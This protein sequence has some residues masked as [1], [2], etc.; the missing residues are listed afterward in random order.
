MNDD[1]DAWRELAEQ[2]A[3]LIATELDRAE[4]AR[5]DDGN[6][7]LWAN[8][9]LAGLGIALRLAGS[10][11]AD[12]EIP[13]ARFVAVDERGFWGVVEDFCTGGVSGVSILGEGL[14]I[15]FAV[16]PEELLAPLP[17]VALIEDEEHGVIGAFDRH[18]PVDLTQEPLLP[19][20]RYDQIDCK[21]AKAAV[22][23]AA[24]PPYGLRTGPEPFW[25]WVGPNGER[26]LLAEV[27][28]LGPWSPAEGAFFAFSSREEA[29]RAQSCLR[30][31]LSL[32][33]SGTYTAAPETWQVERISSLRDWMKSTLVQSKFQISRFLIDPH[34]PR[35]EVGFGDSYLGPVLR[36]SAG[37]WNLEPDGRIVLDHIC[38]EWSERDT[39]HWDGSFGW[40]CNLPRTSYGMP[41]TGPIADK[42]TSSLRA[43]ER[44]AARISE[45]RYGPPDKLADSYLVIQANAVDLSI[46]FRFFADELA[47]LAKLLDEVRTGIVESHGDQ[48]AAWNSR[49]V[50]ENGV[51]G[52]ARRALTEDYDPSRAREVA[53]LANAVLLGNRIEVC[54][55]VTDVAYALRSHPARMELL[56][57]ALGLEGPPVRARIIAGGAYDLEPQAIR[58]GTDALGE[59]VWSALSSEAQWFVGTGLLQK[60]RL[61]TDLHVD[62]AGFTIQLGRAL[63]IE[64]SHLFQEVRTSLEGADLAGGDSPLDR[65]LSGGRDLTIGEAL[66]YLKE[67]ES[68]GSPAAQT[69]RTYI[70]NDLGAGALLVNP[71]V[72][73]LTK[74]NASVR[75][76]SAHTDVVTDEN[77][78]KAM[79]LVLGTGER[80]GLL[81]MLIDAVGSIDY[82]Q[83]EPADIGGRREVLRDA[84]SVKF[85]A[86][87]LA[88]RSPAPSDALGEAPSDEGFGSGLTE[89]V[90]G[91]AVTRRI[92]DLGIMKLLNGGLGLSASF[93]AEDGVVDI[94]AQ[95]WDRETVESLDKA[96]ARK[97][98]SWT[99]KRQCDIDTD[100]P[101]GG[102]VVR[103]T[104][105][106]GKSASVLLSPEQASQFAT[107]VAQ[108]NAGEWGP[109]P[110]RKDSR[111]VFE[112]RSVLIESMWAA[113][114]AEGP[115][116]RMDGI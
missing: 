64:L 56:Y 49:A 87:D 55:Y 18:G 114:R 2:T 21:L 90:P 16:P 36:T 28:D 100:R 47:A 83:D 52:L 81:E 20:R 107:L 43:N 82:R 5:Q 85:S 53:A 54:G 34:L 4:L 94:V 99:K 116:T 22:N 75:T 17:S 32:S 74:F 70:R 40:A 35:W 60:N 58:L 91:A 63:E 112:D 29:V 113:N 72:K 84:I 9:D 50:F 39:V 76:R 102:L 8:G 92:G 68:Y 59:R 41:S 23:A 77:A 13:T 15:Q 71:F 66:Y 88:D 12:D 26:P 3:V 115:A 105:R 24:I 98:V 11:V 89:S 6:A 86:D 65:F 95:E 69:V 31:L 61:G 109:L 67:R 97:I 46:E 30:D 103:F 96:L 25:E 73:N 62:H 51:I 48:G 108:I 7:V 10:E 93:L 106:S 38:H 42:R 57:A 80:K 1:L 110:S 78:E 111:S 14:R 37:V 104:L 19:W 79:A 27:R 44:T 101:T 45:L 33:R